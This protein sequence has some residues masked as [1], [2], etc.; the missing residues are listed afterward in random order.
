[1][2]YHRFSND[3]A[4]Y[5]YDGNVNGTNAETQGTSVAGIS[6]VFTNSVGSWLIGNFAE[7]F[8]K[9]DEYHRLGP[10]PDGDGRPDPGHRAGV[11]RHGSGLFPNTCR[12]TG[13]ATSSASASAAISACA[14]TRPTPESKG[15]IQGDN[16]AY[17]GTADV[18]GS[19]SGV[20]P[21]MNS[22]LELTPDLLLRFVRHAEPEPSDAELAGG[23]GQRVPAT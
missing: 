12:R 15:W 11:Q 23:R 1:M 14:V 16:Y 7:A 5:Y 21:A 13:T 6:S 17:L 3:G 8:A 18:K 4:N 22:V 20:L 9:Y 10:K 19:Y 2:A